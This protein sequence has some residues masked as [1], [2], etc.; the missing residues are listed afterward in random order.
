MNLTRDAIMATVRTLKSEP[1]SVPA[2]GGTVHVRELSANELDTFESSFAEERSKAIKD[3][4]TYRPNVRGRM[5]VACICDAQGN[6]IFLRGDEK[7][8]GDMA[9]HELEG[10]VTVADRLNRFTKS[11]QEALEK[12]FETAGGS[13]SASASPSPGES[14]TPSA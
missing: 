13:D 8:V 6:P 1:V 10:L 3:G 9:A 2:W 4:V 7:L 5:L 14:P 11:H 12:K